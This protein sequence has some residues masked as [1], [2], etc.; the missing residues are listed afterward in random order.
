ML[1]TDYLKWNTVMANELLP[2]VRLYVIKYVAASTVHLD[3][4]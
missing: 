4:I 2:L 1:K 3:L